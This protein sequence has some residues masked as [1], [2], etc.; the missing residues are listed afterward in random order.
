MARLTFIG[1]AVRRLSAAKSPM[2]KSILQASDELEISFG[3]YGFTL[4]NA[5][6]NL[7]VADVGFQA[8]VDGKPLFPSYERAEGRDGQ[9]EA[10]GPLG[11][12]KV[13]CR[14]RLTQ[15]TGT[16][17]VLV[18]HTLTNTSDSLVFL[19][20]A[21]S[22]LLHESSRAVLGQGAAMHLRFCHTDNVRTERFP[23]C[24]EEYPYVR[25]LPTQALRLGRGEDQP[26]PAIYFMQPDYSAG[27]VIAAAA[28]A[29]TFQDWEFCKSA[30]PD[31]VFDTLTIHHEFPQTA[32]FALAPQA[33][34]ELDGTYYE[35]CAATHPQDAFVSYVDYLMTR[36]TF[37]GP[38]TAL[39]ENAF[40]CS[41][42]YGVFADQYSDKLLQ[43]ARFIQ[44]SLPG[45][46][47]FL[48]DAGYFSDKANVSGDVFLDHCYPEPNAAVD[49]AKFP[50]GVR[51]FSD[52]V[53]GM[54]LRPGIWWS[55]MARLKSA[56]FTDHPDWFLR[57]QD[58][59]LLRIGPELG[60]LD[61]TNPEATAFVDR[62]LGILL[63]EWGMDALKMDFWSHNF[64]MRT[65]QVQ[66]LSRTALDGQ[67]TLFALIR[68]HLPPDGIFMTCVATGMGNP[69]VGVA[70]DTYRNTIDIGLGV[71]QE[72]LSNCSWALP[73]LGLEGRKTFLLNGDSVGINLDCPENE[74]YFRLTWGFITMGMQ[75][76]GGRLE[77]LP[78]HYVAALRKY[79]NRCDRGYRCLCPDEDA[80]TGK[81]YPRVL[82][83]D[84]PPDSPTRTS[85]TNQ[86][87]ALF[88]WTDQ[89]Q[90]V[91]IRR[92]LLGH[93]GPVQA[94]NFW[95]EET[96]TFADEFLV[97]RLEPRSALLYDVR[98]RDNSKG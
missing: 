47:Y 41:W 48:V 39:R 53:R 17:V 88:N 86:S 23:Y 13:A 7:G 21:R 78:P 91:S 38:A 57:A 65:G 73:T 49:S 8:V 42:N 29:N 33:S 75:E 82:Y 18:Q 14:T 54:G 1:A 80:W 64:E 77:L 9:I 20:S 59:G 3:P 84:Y 72:Q 11:T 81:P 67:Q 2:E 34:L 60:Y 46:R 25:P 93:V 58:G 79:T 32:L 52:T 94:V 6:Q 22:G 45:I 15:I 37:R 16:P 66:G 68:K 62:V 27:L 83:V 70:A 19:Q 35:L 92:C 76:I 43:T 71:W 74:N 26:F 69:F 96:E 31:S 28:Q 56:L 90:V 50:D 55:P 87:V 95:T 44:E 30:V 85:E 40:Y 89:P 5:A 10:A 51:R 98:Q 61:F 63:K 24:Q 4:L 36:F 12:S 97:K